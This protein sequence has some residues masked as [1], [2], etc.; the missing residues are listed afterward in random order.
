M[1]KVLVTG[2]NGFA[3]RSICKVL[4]LHG[5]QVYALVRK[6]SVHT[7]L[8]VNNPRITL[9]QGDLSSAEALFDLLEKN[10]IEHV[11][12]SAAVVSDWGPKEI[13]YE[14]NVNGTRRLLEAS[15]LAAIKNFLYISTIDVLDYKHGKHTVLS[16]TTPYTSSGHPYQK[17]KLLGELAAVDSR[18]YFKVV[19]LRPA[20]LFGPGDKTLIPEIIHNLKQGFLL[21]PGKKD[22]YIPLLYV[23]NFAFFVRNVLDRI[24]GLPSGTKMNLC[25]DAKITWRQFVTFFK[26]ACNAKAVVVNIPYVLGYVAS[27]LFENYHRLLGI[28]TR[29][30]ITR[31]SL[32]MVTSSLE[33][34][35]SSMKQHLDNGFLSFEKAMDRTVA[36]FN[37]NYCLRKEVH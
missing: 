37:I 16:E 30:M 18:E 19:I 4:A 17:T 31:S 7:Q 23:E 13:F 29:P 34:D 9:L 8:F 32:S 21:L 1:A 2:A 5:Y 36:W 22:T 6:I 10:E 25:D 3:G 27:L 14:V 28:K 12:H 33:V 35:S 26:P 24:D 15:R 11:I 20:W